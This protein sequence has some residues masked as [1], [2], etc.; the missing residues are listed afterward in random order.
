V[1][2]TTHQVV[3]TYNAVPNG[4][5]GGG[6]WTSPSIDASTNTIYVTTGTKGDPSQT[7]S[8]AIVALDAGTLKVKSYWQ[9]P[10]SQAVGDSDWGTT[11]ILFSDSAGHPLVAAT[12]K[13]GTL[14]T[15]ARANLAAG[16]IWQRQVA[17]G[18]ACP[19]CGQGT[20]TSLAFMGG[21]LYVG[22]GNTTI[23]GIGY[24]GSVR[25]LDPATGTPLWEHGAS[26]TVIPALAAANGFIIDGAGNS[27]EVLNAATGARLFSFTTSAPLYAPASVANG[28]IFLAGTDGVIRALSLPSVP[29]P[30]PVPDP[31]CPSGWTCQDIGAPSPAGSDSVSGGAWSVT[32]AGSGIS[33]ASDQFRFLNQGANGDTQ[34]SAQVTALSG[35]GGSAQAGLMVR[36]SI[37]PTAPYYAVFLNGGGNLVVQYRPAFG[38]STTAATQQSASLP[39]YLR[40]QRAGDQFLAA[41]STDG[42]NYALVPGSTATMPMP[43]AVLD[44]AIVSSTQ[45]G[46]TAT[47]GFSGVVVGAPNAPPASPT[48]AT[49]CPGGWTC[50]DIGNPGLVGNQSV[51]GNTWTVQGA[52]SDIW[53]YT[54]QFHYVWQPL[55]GDGSISARVTGQSNTDPWAK[56]G[57]MLRQGTD[58]AAAYYA[59]F[60]TPSNGITVQA[61][62]SEGYNTT[63]IFIPGAIPAYLRVARSGNTFSA[64]TSTDGVA[65]TLIPGSSTTLTLTGNLLAGLAVTAHN[66]GALSTVTFDS[67]SLAPAGT[68]GACP[69]GWNCADIGNPALAGSQSLS[70]NTWTVQGGGY[71]IWNAA[72]QFH[73]IWQPL[74]GD[75]SLSAHVT[76][77]SNTDP[78]AKAGVMLRQDT[79]PS[80]P[81][82]ALFVTPDNGI[83]VDYRASQGSAAIMAAPALPGGVPAYLKVALAG[84]TF[85][86]LT[87]TDGAAWTL[88][89]GSSVSLNLSGSLLVGLAVTAHNGGAL[90]T[91]AFDSVN[92]TPSTQPT[93][94]PTSSPT[95][96]PTAITGPCPS[97]WS[98]GD[99]GS[100]ALT[101]G[102]SLSGSTW[103]L[104]GSGYD[105]WN[106][107]DQFHYVWQ[108]LAGDGSLSARVI[109][110]SNTDPWAKAGVMLRQTTDPAAGFYALFITPGN[111]IVVDYRADQGSTAI[112]AAPAL[113]GATPAY[114]KV[115]RVG[116]TFSAYTSNDGTTWSLVPGSTLTLNLSGS[117]LAGLAVTAHNSGA[118]S[119]VTFDSASLIASAQSTSTPTSTAIP[120]SPTNTATSTPTTTP[121]NTATST[122]TSTPT[123]TNG[124][125]PSS[126]SCGD[127][128]NPALAGGQSLSG[129]IWTVQGSGYDIWNAIDQFHYIW[130]S[131]TGDGSLSAHVTTQSP[132]DPWAKAGVMLRQ[133]TD[134]SAPFYALFATPGNGIVVDYRAGQGITAIQAAPAL[135]GTVPVYLKVTRTGSTF[136]AYTSSDG[137]A[138]T[139]VPGSTLTLN[140]SASLLAGLAVTAHNG[141]ALSTVTFDSVNLTP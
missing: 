59:V 76:A 28:Q 47:V 79:D 129:N 19:T 42:V 121:T 25:A 116:S 39:L 93:S 2:L 105:V 10:D 132:A 34:I 125:C 123:A 4:Q 141:G 107:L 60:V 82:Y 13:N 53:A 140:L 108:P 11:P 7:Q 55:D 66:S 122:P 50:G 17:I 77:Q 48:P 31:N 133:G 136:S 27:L 32:A 115:A 6:I 56:A 14:Y 21:T 43:S 86:A 89:P 94:T 109:A 15:F 134:P 106:A 36:Q 64:Y 112:Q 58:P 135:P 120:P 71:D 65:W 103:T 73:S 26:G 75:G 100:P 96:T 44:G 20:V 127:I 69:S 131:L 37:D 9:L 95:S 137:T 111:G 88:V 45:A 52:G 99:L 51:S 35:S 102:Q 49:P 5:I 3:N 139:L 63:P 23:N 118:L 84:S 85:S 81:F 8:Q 54:D 33:G 41:T 22:S 67:V 72:D 113:S 24:Q 83:V 114:L 91:A 68:S 119:T 29:P 117:L 38:G 126:W 80:A 78:W 90:S 124:N 128:D 138:W 104:Q 16:P 98:C 92:L 110:Q 18:G 40:I 30:T 62:P 130:Q 12:N 74:A 70:G 101:G 57:I 97:G 46:G 1:D 61:R 87:S